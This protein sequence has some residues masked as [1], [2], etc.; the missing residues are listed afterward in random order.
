MNAWKLLDTYPWTSSS[1]DVEFH[2]LLLFLIVKLVLPLCASLKETVLGLREVWQ[3]SGGFSTVFSELKKSVVRTMQSSTPTGLMFLGLV[4]V[5]ISLM[6][7]ACAIMFSRR[8]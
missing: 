1:W 3:E 4:L 6:T 8:R 7:L 2:L 5:S